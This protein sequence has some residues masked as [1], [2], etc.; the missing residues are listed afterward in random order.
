MVS[1][2]RKNGISILSIVNDIPIRDVINARSKS[3]NNIWGIPHYNM[4]YNDAHNDRAKSIKIIKD[5]RP[6][7]LDDEIK[8]KAFLP[9][10]N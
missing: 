1:L 7:F 3:K 9:A 8:S 10:F 2:Y 4:S 5:K 6:N